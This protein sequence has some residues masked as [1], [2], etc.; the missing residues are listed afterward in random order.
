MIKDLVEQQN[1]SK[2]V[3]FAR[4]LTA[5]LHAKGIEPSPKV[6]ATEFNLYSK[7]EAYKPQ[8][9]RKWLI[10]LSQPKSETMLLLAIWLNIN[11]KDLISKPEES[12]SCKARIE[13]DYTDQEV[14][15]KYLAMS[16]NQKVAIRLVI[17]AIAE[18]QR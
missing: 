14:I 18:K 11:P 13:F 15:S 8:T 7:S 2:N 6:V 10:G 12:V 9:V 16:A 4:Q 17:D 5:A 1:N 3:Y